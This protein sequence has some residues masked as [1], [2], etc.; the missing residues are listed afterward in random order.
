MYQQTFGYSYFRSSLNFCFFIQ[1]I[2][3]GFDRLSDLGHS[4]G[5]Q[6]P[7]C[8]IPLFEYFR[9]SFNLLMRGKDFNRITLIEERKVA[10]NLVSEYGLS[11]QVWR[12]F[13]F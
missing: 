13:V 10:V 1:P 8:F 3:K 9:L 2:E 7:G 5:E 12:A 4:L 6:V 11:E